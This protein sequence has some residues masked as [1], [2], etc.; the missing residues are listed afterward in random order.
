MSWQR[1]KYH[2]G[3]LET[4]EFDLDDTIKYKQWEYTDRTKL[5]SLESTAADFIDI[6]CDHST[7]TISLQNLSLSFKY[8]QGKGWL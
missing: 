6:M 1:E 7:S 5:I 8:V 3:Q 4:N 2:K